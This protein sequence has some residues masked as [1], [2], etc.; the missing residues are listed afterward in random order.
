MDKHFLV[1]TVPSSDDQ[2]VIWVSTAIHSCF[3]RKTK[4]IAILSLCKG[5]AHDRDLQW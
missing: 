5:S 4:S 2:I 1:M 3:F